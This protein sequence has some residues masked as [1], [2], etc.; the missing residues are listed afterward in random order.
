MKNIAGI[1]ICFMGVK[2]KPYKFKQP[3]VQEL[4]K[5]ALQFLG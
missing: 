5:Q 2:Q 4:N 3:L 1:F